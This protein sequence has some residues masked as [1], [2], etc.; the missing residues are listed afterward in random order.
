M[1]RRAIRNR[2]RRMPCSRLRG[3]SG[4]PI[5]VEMRQLGG[6]GEGEAGVSHAKSISLL[7]ASCSAAERGFA[8]KTTRIPLECVYAVG[9]N[10]A[11]YM[12]AVKAMPASNGRDSSQKQ[13]YC[14]IRMYK[15]EL[16]HDNGEEEPSRSGSENIFCCLRGLNFDQENQHKLPKVLTKFPLPP[17]IDLANNRLF[18]LRKL[19]YL[20]VLDAWMF[21][22]ISGLG[23]NVER[24]HACSTLLC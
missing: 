1:P 8:H 18:P 20:L 19:C 22:G 12:H 4:F 3:S 17:A 5:L 16:F 10:V 14:S 2:P 6:R 24:H 15:P 13:Q 7:C 21:H 9:G 11:Q 23:S